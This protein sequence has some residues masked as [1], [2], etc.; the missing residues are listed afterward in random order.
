MLRPREN[1]DSIKAAFKAIGVHAILLG[2]LLFSFN[3]KAAH[4]VVEVSEV[5]L[6]DKLPKPQSVIQ[7]IPKPEPVLAPK[8]EPKEE[9]KLEPKP[10]PRTVVEDKPKPEESKVDIALEKQKKALAEKEKEKELDKVKREK[11][12]TA[13]KIAK[14]REETLQ[15]KPSYKQKSEKIDIDNQQ[16]IEALKKEAL[17]DLGQD[18]KPANSAANASKIGEYTDKIKAIIR[19]KVN[20]TVCG[21]SNPEIRFSINVLPTGQLGGTPKITKSSGID[22]CDEA[23]ERAII[24]SEPLPLPDDAELKTHFRNL[25]LKFRPND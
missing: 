12:E 20:K 13:K 19:N 4:H 3:W 5:E 18:E 15:E 24:A 17:N 11:E 7:N 6:W 14:M 16:K 21:D 9:P 2:A 22:A 8:P 23:L 1:A 25:N 10:E